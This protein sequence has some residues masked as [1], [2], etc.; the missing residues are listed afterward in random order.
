MLD[1]GEFHGGDCVDVAVVIVVNV[2]VV[3]RCDAMGA[4]MPSDVRS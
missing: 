1:N 2:A 4:M 3:G